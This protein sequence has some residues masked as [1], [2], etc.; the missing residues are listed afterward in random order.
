MERT[1]SLK[2]GFARPEASARNGLKNEY[3]PLKQGFSEFFM[4]F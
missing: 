2:S 1:V 3:L 4:T